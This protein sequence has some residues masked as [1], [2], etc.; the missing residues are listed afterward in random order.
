MLGAVMGVI[1]AV[2][3]T[4]AALLLVFPAIVG[5]LGIGLLAVLFAVAV[6]ILVIVL[7]VPIVLGSLGLALAIMLGTVLLVGILIALDWCVSLIT[8]W[9]F[10]SYR[11]EGAGTS[12]TFG[13]QKRR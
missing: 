4:A 13:W 1:L 8:G 5:S 7:V 3:V 11:R 12:I 2:I 6:A 10:L 9:G